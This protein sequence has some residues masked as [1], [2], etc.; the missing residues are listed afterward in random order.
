MD[1]LTRIT[2]WLKPEEKKLIEDQAKAAGK[3]T[4]EYIKDILLPL[5]TKESE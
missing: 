5:R 2:L 4:S 1:K 3:K